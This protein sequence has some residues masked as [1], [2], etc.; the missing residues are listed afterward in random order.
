LLQR[1][2]AANDE[3]RLGESAQTAARRG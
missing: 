1:V 3:V 2:L